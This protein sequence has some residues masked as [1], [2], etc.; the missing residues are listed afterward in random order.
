M[1]ES[2]F[3][4]LDKI[5]TDFSWRR[6]ITFITFFLILGVIFFLAESYTDYFSLNRLE[7]E[8]FLLKEIATLKP[9][10]ENDST[11]KII[12]IGL[13]KDLNDLVNNKSRFPSINPYLLRFFVGAFPWIILTLAFIPGFKKGTTTSSTIVGGIIFIIIFGGIGLLIPSSWGST[14]HYAVY[15]FGHFLIVSLIALF[16]QAKK[17]KAT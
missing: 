13:T 3:K 6:L 4:F 11:L 9:K 17:R 14:I 2:I 15:P 16:L 5:V 7:K 10:I 8:T 12:Y 1:F